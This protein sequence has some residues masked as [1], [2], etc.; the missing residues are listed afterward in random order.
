MLP[1]QLG[2]LVPKTMLLSLWLHHNLMKLVVICSLPVAL[3]C[4]SVL[5]VGPSGFTKV[6]GGLGLTPDSWGA[7]LRAWPATDPYMVLARTIS[8]PELAIISLQYVTQSS[9][10][11]QRTVLSSHTLCLNFRPS[12]YITLNMH[13]IFHSCSFRFQDSLLVFKTILNKYN[14]RGT[15]Q[16]M[17]DRLRS[18]LLFL[19]S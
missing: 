18:A 8:H 3:G 19:Q 2:S 5:T 10:C 9:L 14:R 16:P 13:T 11:S 15:S 4:S 1:C 12:P 7:L 17:L 6:V